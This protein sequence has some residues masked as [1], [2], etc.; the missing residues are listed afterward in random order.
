[1]CPPKWR[2]RWTCASFG[3]S[4]STTKWQIDRFSRFCTAHGRVSSGSL[5]PPG[6]Y[7]WNCA[8]WRHH[9]N[10]IELVLPSAHPGLPPKRQINQFSRF[11]T[12]HGRYYTTGTPFLKNCPFPW[13][14]LDRHLTHD[15]LGPS[16]S[17]NQTASPSPF[18]PFQP[19]LHRWPQSV[20]LV[21]NGMPFPPKISDFH[22]GSGP[23]SNTWF[24]GPTWVL[25]PNS[26]SNLNWFSRFCSAH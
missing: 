7:D 25:N 12:A 3:P 22:G 14:D 24:P 1:M 8:Q 4:K 6:E 2:I 20:P 16:K 11:C 5:A 23:Q 21:Y 9:A 19:F 15:S 17:I 10:M 18:L 26:I 13:E